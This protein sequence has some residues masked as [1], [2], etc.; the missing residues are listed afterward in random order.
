MEKEE[1]KK[2]EIDQTPP[3][4]GIFVK[5]VVKATSIFGA[6]IPPKNEQPRNS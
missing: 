1:T 4:L 3:T 5:E 6:P 2:E